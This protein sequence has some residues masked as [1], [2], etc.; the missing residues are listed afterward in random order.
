MERE[1]SIDSGREDLADPGRE[2]ERED[3]ADPGRD[4]KREPFAELGRNVAGD[5]LSE[6]STDAVFDIRLD[7][8]WELDREHLRLDVL[9]GSSSEVD[10]VS[11]SS[12]ICERQALPSGETDMLRVA[13]RLK[14]A[15]G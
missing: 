4:A 8:D 11:V 14:A 12:I 2:V 7:A 3:L 10:V 6:P 15:G 5:D 13:R 9:F 1:D